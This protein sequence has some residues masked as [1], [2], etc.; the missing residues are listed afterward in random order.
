MAKVGDRFQ[1]GNKCDTSGSYI[2]DGYTDNT[3]RK[4]PTNE[5]RVIP[6]SKGET[7]PP[8][9]STQGGAWWKLQRIT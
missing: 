8:I 4:Q 5:E 1:T 9:K 6:L 3:P 2:F 7:F